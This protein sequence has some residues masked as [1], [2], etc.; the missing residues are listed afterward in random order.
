MNIDRSKGGVYHFTPSTPKETPKS[1][2]FA[3]ESRAKAD[4]L[5]SR[6]EAAKDFFQRADNQEF[7]RDPRQGHV[8]LKDVPA[9]G[10]IEANTATVSG[11]MTSSIGFLNVTGKPADAKGE[12]SN[13]EITYHDY[14]TMDRAGSANGNGRRTLET[15]HARGDEF[16][17]VQWQVAP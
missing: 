10:L 8:S 7:D 3:W 5:E 6:S 1:N 2:Y 17:T 9:A 16:R 14:V 15:F 13:L 4:H 12:T 11:V